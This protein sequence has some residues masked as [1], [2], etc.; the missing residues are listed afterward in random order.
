MAVCAALGC[1]ETQDVEVV[2]T[3]EYGRR[4]LCPEHRTELEVPA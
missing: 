2:T 1:L 3:A 4:A